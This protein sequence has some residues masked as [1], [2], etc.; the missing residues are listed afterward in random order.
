MVAGLGVFLCEVTPALAQSP[1]LGSAQSFAVVGGQSVTVAGTGTTITGDVGV[2]P[3]TSITGIPGSGTVAPPFSTHSND[4]AAMAAQ[5]SVASL[6]ATLAGASGA[7]P[8]AAELG[9]LTITPGTYSF[10]S[11]ANIAATTTLTL[12]GAGTYIFKVGSAITANVG[13]N[14]VLING[15]SPCNVFWQIT[16]AATLN[17]ATFSGT[18]VAQ[19]AVTLGAGA[20]LIGRALTTAAG[21]VTMAG[22]NTVGGCSDPAGGCPTISLAPATLPG[23]TVGV[24]YSQTI[25]GSGGSAPYAF[26]VSAGTLPPGL[27]LTSAGALTGTPTTAGTFTFTIRGTD[28]NGCL[29]TLAYTIIIAAPPPVCPVITLGPATLPGGTVG[30]AYSQT[31]TGSGGSAPYAFDVSAGTLPPGLGLTSAGAL[32]GTPTTAGTFT[33]TIRGTDANGCLA[34]L[35][36]TIIIARTAAG[37]SRHHPRPGDTARRHGGRRLQSDDHWKR[38]QRAIRLRC[39]GGHAPARSG[40]D[41][42]RR[43]DGHTDDR[44]HFHVHDSRH[45]CQRLPRH[46]RVHNHHRGTAAGA[47]GVS[48][49]HALTNDLAGRYHGNRLPGDHRGQWGTAPYAFGM[50]GGALPSGLTLRASGVLS[51]IPTM[52]GQ[53]I[54]TV[55]ATATGGCFAERDFA[56]AILNAVPTLPQIVIVLLAS[57]LIS[58]GYLRLRRRLQ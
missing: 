55:R 35:A 22:S 8:I 26:D 18:V 6:Y 52:A 28:A 38:W 27:G 48:Y 53:S 49:D 24:A 50:T 40:V 36:Y 34:T 29:A 11:T 47:A 23:G 56:I 42:R 14:V 45:R 54:A 21:D 32:T 3:G 43:T 39:L 20:E 44:R 15:A 17:G 2:S 9:G 46:A 25:T 37:V 5:S 13:S 12:S 7:V 1:S 30:A 4:A 58:I 10:A 16:S 33:F 57:G 31:I 51:G 41:V 19:A